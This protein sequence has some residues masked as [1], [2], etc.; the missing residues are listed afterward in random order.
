M[1]VHLDGCPDLVVTAPRDEI[2]PE[3]PLVCRNNGSGQFS[4]LPREH[5]V[6]GR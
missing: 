3:S 1:N 6:S 4:P 5:F 2:R